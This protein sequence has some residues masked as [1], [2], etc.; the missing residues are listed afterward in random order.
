MVALAGMASLAGVTTLSSKAL[1]QT[2]TLTQVFAGNLTVQEADDVAEWG[3]AYF[4]KR[5]GTSVGFYTFTNAAMN[6]HLFNP[7]YATRQT[8]SNLQ[9]V[10]LEDCQEEIIEA[11]S[12][13]PIRWTKRVALKNSMVA[14]QLSTDPVANPDG[15]FSHVSKILDSLYLGQVAT[16]YDESGK[17][18]SEYVPLDLIVSASADPTL[19]ANI[20]E[21][22]ITTINSLALVLPAAAPTL[23]GVTE[24]EKLAMGGISRADKVRTKIQEILT[25]RQS[26]AYVLRIDA[27]FGV[28]GLLPIW[29]VHFNDC[30]VLV[31][32]ITGVVT[33]PRAVGTPMAPQD[34]LSQHSDVFSSG[35]GIRIRESQ[36]G[37]APTVAVWVPVP[38]PMPPGT[39]PLAPAPPLQ[40]TPGNPTTRCQSIALSCTCT[41][42][43]VICV[44]ALP[45]VF[46]GAPTSPRCPGGVLMQELTI[47]TWPAGPG[48]CA[49]PN[50]VGPA[51]PVPP[52]PPVP[53]AACTTTYGYW[54]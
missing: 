29:V 15:T 12:N 31:D 26:N 33:A 46:P 7:L 49:W 21:D 23:G 48:G 51:L 37:C 39:T 35:M 36:N 14:N 6:H 45:G 47:C 11:T 4:A 10:A 28:Y 32:G 16:Y 41:M 50:P 44:P 19:A 3:T 30:F 20:T 17:L 8:L 5:E 1:A 25:Q 24:S 54:N 2:S 22:N 34:L 40:P 42:Q 52:A 18:I 53:A 13:D 27:Q 9:T 43:R 38:G